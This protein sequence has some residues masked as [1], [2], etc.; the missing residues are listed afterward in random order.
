MRMKRRARS[1]ATSVEFAFVAPV[2][3]TLILGVMVG[4]L[5][6]FR[7]QEIATLAREAARYASVHGAQYAKETGNTAATPQ[8]VYDNVISAKAVILD[9]SQ[10]TYSVTWNT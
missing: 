5:A 9:L 1:G 2:A 4:G 10:L 8:S 6:V 3:L 7:F